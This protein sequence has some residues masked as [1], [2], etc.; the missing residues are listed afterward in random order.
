MIKSI[1]KLYY[2]TFAKIVVYMLQA[3]EY[4][5]GPYLRW[6]WRINNFSGVMHRKSLVMTK[7]ARLLVLAISAGF[8][9][10]ELTSAALFGI[11]LS[12]DNLPLAL[13]AASVF[14]LTPVLW[15]HLAVLPLLAGDN[16][17]TKPFTWLQVHR[18]TK[19]F[20]K[21]PGVKIAVAGSYGKTTMK[22]ILL[23]VLSEGKKVAATPANKNVAFSH[24]QFAQKLDGDEEILIIEYGEG[25]PG[26]VARFVKNTHPDIGVI[27][28]LAPA[29]L[30]KYKTLKRAGEDIFTLAHY[31]ANKKVYIN[32]ESEATM[33]WLKKGHLLYSKKQAAGWEVTDIKATITGLSFTMRKDDKVLSLKSGLL[34]T[35]QVGPLA[36]AAAVAD[37]LGL[38]KE[39]IQRGVAKIKPFEHRMQPR[40]VGGAWIIDDTYNGNIEGMLAGLKL[41][42]ELPAKR[43][44]Y[45]TPGLVGQGSE[46]PV[47][48]YRL[49][50]AI[51][52][53]KPDLVILMQN[54]VVNY[55]TRGIKAKK[56]NG[57]LVIEEDPLNFYLHLDQFVATG[58]LVLLQNDWPDNYS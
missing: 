21:H 10:Q 43:K 31:L 6:F 55:I 14:I 12:R 23:S 7:K 29:H 34:G 22:E 4:Q 2:P 38:N 36:V 9:V 48:H 51:S 40:E 24:A 3:T 26:D 1:L 8:F 41:L 47:I 49:G 28:G 37:S 35:H 5:V 53:A 39:Q 52:D 15:G 17:I 44:I 16:V 46:S 19:I 27:T 32:G 18:S 11:A 56:Y 42:K 54:S 33:P 20:A 45:V 25:A 30:D 13:F 58:D 57:K 50:E